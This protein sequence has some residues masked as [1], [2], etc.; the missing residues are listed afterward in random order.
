MV[1]DDYNFIEKL[2]RGSFGHVLL[3]ETHPNITHNQPSC[4]EI[5]ESGDEKKEYIQEAEVS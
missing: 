2:G 1:Q 4:S 3:A 5:L